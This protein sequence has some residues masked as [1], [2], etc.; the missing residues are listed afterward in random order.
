MTW[1]AAEVSAPPSTLTGRVARLSR[2]VL[3]ALGAATAVSALVLLLLVTVQAPRVTEV[4][5]GARAV[6]LSHLAMV[7]QETGLRAYLLTRDDAS[8]Q[9][10]E[11]GRAELDRRN[12]DARRSFTGD[13]EQLE[14]LDELETAQ[15]SWL[16]GWAEPALD[17]VPRGTTAAAFVAE[18]QELFDDYR[19]VERR[20]EGAADDLRERADERQVLVLVLAVAVEVALL[21]VVATLLRREFLRL[22]SDVVTPVQGLVT[23]IDRLREGRLDARPEL[24]GPAELRSVGEGLASMA[25][26]LQRARE[27]AEERERELVAARH[28]AEEATHAKSAFL[29]TMSHELRTPMNAVIGMTGLLLDTD[30]TPDQRDF[31]ETVRSSGD[32]L[33]VVINDILDFSKIEA[34]ELELERLPFSVRDCVEGSLDLVAAQ[35]G[36]KGLDLAGR[37]ADDVPLAVVGD[38]TRLRQ[39]LVNLL[40]NAVKFTEHGEV[41]L[42]AHLAGDGALV[43]A[44][45]DTGIGIPADRLDRLFR[46]FSQVDA[47]TTRMYGG[48]GLGLAISRRIAEAMGGTITVESTP[49][50]G[51]VFALTVSLP[52]GEQ[53]VD[54]LAAPPAELPGRHALVVDD[55]ATNREILRRQLTAWGMSVEVHADGAAA[56]AAVDA[57]GAYD[58]VL[59]DMHMPGMDGVALAKELRAREGTRDLPLLLLTSLGSR[60]AEAGA[61]GLLH[62]TKPVKAAALQTVVASALGASRAPAKAETAPVLQRHLRV[63]LAEDN[64]VN[65]RVALLML[66]RLGYRAD[67]V[68]NGIE[69][70][71][72]VTS[73]PYDVVLM[74]VQMPELDGVGATQRLRAQLPP[75]RQPRI[76]AMTAGALAEDRK[77]CLAAGMDDFLGKPVRREELA[78]ALSRAARTSSSD[79]RVEVEV[80]APAPPGADLPVVDPSVLGSLAERLG[81]RAAAFLASLLGTWETETAARMAAVATAVEAGDAEAV[82]RAAHAVKGGSGSMG[83]LRLAAVCAQ[84]EADVVAGATNLTS[85][86]QRLAAE[87]EQARQ[88]LVALY[89]T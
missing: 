8:L 13:E 58:V 47:S 60:P 64:V 49:G 56:L 80:A 23:T 52:R 4:N 76:I 33:L 30:L 31:A 71:Q 29:A 6:R 28:E 87:V 70:V 82:G 5:E 11:R 17:G 59:L 2:V 66:D 19:A 89:R 39:V 44:V 38:V 37:I 61:L 68:A 45:R 25:A 34:G 27:A 65:Q 72:A 78:A 81:P 57:G 43:F 16:T 63:L 32:A 54:A 41:V 24:S 84:V 15:R 22:R 9:P 40:S 50:E 62:L 88:A 35:A 21:L 79:E 86:Q 77:R 26:S 7:D 48:T 67:V 51:S 75:E 20:V 53:T 83:A 85:A 69:A 55:N 14:L 74:D 46:S 10:Y 1:Q 3:G 42:D 12:E 18:G 73:T 36:A